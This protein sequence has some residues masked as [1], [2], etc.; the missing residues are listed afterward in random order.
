MAALRSTIDAP[1]RLLR[2]AYDWTIH[3]ADSPQ[4]LLALFLIAVAE[5][6]FFP[7]PPDVLLIAIVAARPA[8]WLQAAA[9]CSAGSFIG[10]AIGYA[11]G[12]ALMATVG[13]VIIGFYGAEH[14]WDRFVALADAWGAWFL[15]AAAFTPIPFKVATIASGAI[16]MPFAAFLGI[17]LIGRAG[18]FFLVA[19]LLRLFGERIRR[20]I[21]RNF[22]VV[23][24]LFFALLIGGFLLLRYI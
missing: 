2:R 4:G 1:R 10:A 15:A 3:W 8:R 5:S 21:E 6:S 20:T 16:E 22:D 9:V 18:R 17:S 23:S 24:L 11:I 14:H 19:T 7:I 12:S 13:D